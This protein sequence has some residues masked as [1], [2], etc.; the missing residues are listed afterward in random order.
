MQA[1]HQN[2]E[3]DVHFGAGDIGWQALGPAIACTALAVIVVTMRWYTR[4][5]VA[6]CVGLDDYVIFI[7][8]V[9]CLRFL[10][11]AHSADR[12]L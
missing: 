1:R 11:I 2:H 7:S 4:W 12:V 10:H 5:K 6:D 9:F 8:M 3:D